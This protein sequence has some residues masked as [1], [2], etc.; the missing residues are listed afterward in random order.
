MKRSVLKS[1]CPENSASCVFSFS[2][3]STGSSTAGFLSGSIAD[4]TVRI[5]LETVHYAGLLSPIFPE[6]SRVNFLGLDI[7]RTKVEGHPLQEK[8]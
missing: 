6:F 8:S 4:N 3:L 1:F 2:I 7:Y 5:Y